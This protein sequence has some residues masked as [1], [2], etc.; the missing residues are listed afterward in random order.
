LDLPFLANEFAETRC[1]FE[2]TGGAPSSEALQSA[3]NVIEAKAHF[4]GPE[5]P[6]HVRVGAHEGRLYLDL[7]P[8]EYPARGAAAVPRILW[9]GGEP[10]PAGKRAPGE[11]TMPE[12]NSTGDH[13]KWLKRQ[14]LQVVAQLPEDP[15]DAMRVLDLAVGLLRLI[16]EG[17]RTC[18]ISGPGWQKARQA[19]T[20]PLAA[21]VEG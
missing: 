16:E 10:Q 5:R 17:E 6:V 3:L 8:G 19:I 12:P 18:L 9:P 11:A 21:Q 2:T 7:G 15:R 13:E 4:D 20:H 1:F 14:A